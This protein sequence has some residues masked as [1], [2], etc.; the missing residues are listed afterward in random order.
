MQDS[1]SQLL[2]QLFLNVSKG[3]DD[4]AQ[5]FT[6]LE[7]SV[8]SALTNMINLMDARLTQL[9]QQL[10]PSTAPTAPTTSRKRSAPDTVD[11]EIAAKKHR[12]K[13]ISGRLG[14]AFTEVVDHACVR[15]NRYNASWHQ[16]FP[17]S[18]MDSLRAIIKDKMLYLE[19][20]GLDAKAAEQRTIETFSKR[21]MN[22]AKSHEYLHISPQDMAHLVDTI[23]QHAGPADYL[24]DGPDESASSSESDE[25]TIPTSSSVSAP[26]PVATVPVAAQAPSDDTDDESDTPVVAAAVAPHEDSDSDTP[27]T[28]VKRAPARKNLKTVASKPEPKYPKYNAK[29]KAGMITSGPLAGIVVNP[30]FC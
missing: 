12:S 14:R 30:D 19:S 3:H 24:R 15:S 16:T 26:P 7:R 29:R 9:S 2:L 21:M 20:I 11:P 28:P 18:S 6:V 13:L 8:S 22:F 17:V 25:D 27:V 23:M 10:A 5:R 4:L 1:S